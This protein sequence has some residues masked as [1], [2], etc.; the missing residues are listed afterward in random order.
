MEKIATPEGFLLTY[1]DEYRDHLLSIAEDIDYQKAKSIMAQGLAD[2]M[3]VETDAELEFFGFFGG[4][5]RK[6][7]ESLEESLL[8]VRASL[9][10]LVARHFVG[11]ISMDTAAEIIETLRSIPHSCITLG[12]VELRADQFKVHWMNSHRERREELLNRLEEM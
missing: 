7:P 5:G 9:E 6:E 12:G 8:G 2:Y 10:N 11:G 3:G 4:D 1:M